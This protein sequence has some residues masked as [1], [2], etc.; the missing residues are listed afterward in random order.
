M[1][2][3]TP[4]RQRFLEDMQ[5]RGLA[6]TTQ[7][8]YVSAVQQLAAYYG[9][10]PD[11]ITN[12]QL[13][14]YFLYLINE[15]EIA[16]GTYTVAISSIRFLYE[17]TLQRSWSTLELV[18]APREK[19]QPVVLSRQ[20]VHQ[21]L[22]CLR[23]EHQRVCLTTIYSCGLRPG[24]GVSLQVRDIDSSR[25]VIHVRNAKGGKDRHV[26]LAEQTLQLLR[27]HWLTH[28]HLV[29]LFPSRVEG[30]ALAQAT[31]PMATAGVLKAFHLARKAS[32]VTKEATVRTL[33]HSYA[34]HLLE[35][36]VSLRLIQAY[37]GHSYMSTTASY[38]H[39]TPHIEQPASTA[40]NDL[41]EGWPWS[42]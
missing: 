7:Q 40:I 9:K 18:R 22:N 11:K 8:V 24:E 4:L 13:R 31:K 25:M 34:T 27:A 20:E 42:S 21:I 32:G 5:L 17:Q 6:P 26:P 30:P 12:E 3:M 16:R 41:M 38:T 2:K 10:S 35:A 23:S 37:L 14:E 33:R 1:V 15:K 39:L 29:W 36:G 19:K 28:R